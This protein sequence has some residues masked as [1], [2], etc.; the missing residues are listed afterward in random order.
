MLLITVLLVLTALV[1]NAQ[2]ALVVQERV[3]VSRALAGH[4]DVGI[5]KV[6]AKGV[7]GEMCSPD[8]KTIL[9]STK[10]DETGHFS[11]ERPRTGKL[12]YVKLSAPGVNPNQLRVCL[13][14]GAPELTIHLDIAT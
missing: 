13:K 5:T 8:W 2:S 10:T 14:K 4:V 6:P 7:T 1:A 12:F 9:A 11:L 3:A